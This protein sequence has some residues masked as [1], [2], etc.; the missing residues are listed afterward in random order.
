M[1]CNGCGAEK[2]TLVC[3]YCGGKKQLTQRIGVMR[4]LGPPRGIWDE[5]INDYTRPGSFGTG[6]L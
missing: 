5:K 4:V 3:E 6:K 2:E 1:K